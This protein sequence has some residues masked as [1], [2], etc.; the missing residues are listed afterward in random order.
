M[1][2]SSLSIFI[3]RYSSLAALTCFLCL[4]PKLCH[5]Q[6]DVLTYHNNNSRTGLNSKETTLTPANVNSATFG[7]LF[8]VTVDGLVDAQPLYL[9]AVST[10]SG[11]HNLLIVVSEHASAYAFDADSGALVWQVTALK[12]GETA[13]DDRGCGQVSPE[14]GI[15]STPVIVRPKNSNGV[16][17]LVAMSKDSSGNY[18]QRLHALDAA[19]GNELHKGPVD[20]A[21]QFPG[22]GD[23]SANGFVIF[24]PAAYKERS[25]L[26]FLGNTIY[27]AWASHCDN[28]PYTGWIMGYN[29]TTLAQT[30]VLNVTPNGNEGAIWGAER[31]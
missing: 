13:S 15:T 16:I 27:L 17:Y 1:R 2:S 30:T 7:K 19:T 20:I 9:H 31:A 21:A 28:R 14:I 23:N 22:A 29:A 3:R 26:L 5:S 6:Q 10:A 25:G 12:S 11:M 8:T 24:D 18:H 4:A